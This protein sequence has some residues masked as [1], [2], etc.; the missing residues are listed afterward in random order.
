MKDDLRDAPQEAPAPRVWGAEHYNISDARI[1]ST[2]VAK[3]AWAIFGS[4]VSAVAGI[5]T[6]PATIFGR[7]FVE[8]WFSMPDE[9]RAVVAG[10]ATL[11]A[12]MW[13]SA[14]IGTMLPWVKGEFHW[15]EIPFILSAVIVTILV[16]IAGAISGSLKREEWRKIARRDFSRDE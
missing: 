16:T 3:K 7:W 13:C 12:M 5:F 11:L 1:H 6:R 15:W 14:Y 4:M 10:I 9:G 8:V 2:R